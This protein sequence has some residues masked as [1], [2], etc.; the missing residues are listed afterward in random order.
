LTEV[1]IAN[2]WKRNIR[3]HGGISER[4]ATPAPRFEIGVN[5][6]GV[7]QAGTDVQKLVVPED[8][9]RVEHDFSRR[10]ACSQLALVVLPPALRDTRMRKSAL[11]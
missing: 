1:V 8:R 10:S 5:G 6:A 11:M 3:H 2:H 4:P 7:F 9:L